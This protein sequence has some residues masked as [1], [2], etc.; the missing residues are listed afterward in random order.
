MNYREF[1]RSLKEGAPEDVYVFCGQEDYLRRDALQRLKA[2]LLPAGLEDL[3]CTELDAPRADQIIASA[4]TL[5]LMCERRLVIAHGLQGLSGEA[6]PGKKEKK[7]GASSEEECEALLRYLQSPP[8]TACIVIDAGESIDKR[9]KLGK[10]LIALPGYV[11]FDPPDDEA[12]YRFLSRRAAGM[13]T[14][15]T[16]EAFD[17]L[18]F[19]SG[20]D[21]TAL[22]LELD[23]LAAHAAGKA[24]IDMQ[25]VD[26]V[27]TRSAE[28]RVFD[29]IDAVT[30]RQTDQAFA[31]LKVLLQNG[32]ARLGILAL[33][34]RQYRQMLY[35]RDMAEAG[36][37]QA[38]IAAQMGMKPFA[39]GRLAARTRRMDAGM[40]K[41][42]LT[43][44]IRTEFAVKNG[45]TRE[46]AALDML[47][48]R[49][50]TE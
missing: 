23:K 47:L 5:P 21:M 7:Q 31:Q 34:T 42:Q 36:R 44:C 12:L 39:V 46:D 41:A 26:A 25:D 20:R 40:L 32:E 50:C 3:N 22:A 35:V 4:E 2:R 28:A 37:S 9:R 49:L 11:S 45:T 15:L 33:V 1:V 18:L 29:M 48:I 24:A 8:D 6:K 13:G 43:D 17:R 16:R 30:A 38:E 19:Y 14:G 10:T 27:A